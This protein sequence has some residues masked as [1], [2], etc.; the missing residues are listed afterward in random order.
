MISSP[1]YPRPALFRQR[2]TGAIRISGS[3]HLTWL[4]GVVT[5][6]VTAAE[7]GAFWG[8]LLDRMGKIHY[9]V[10]GILEPSSI[11]VFDVSQGTNAL[12]KY[13]DSVLI[14]EDVTL[15]QLNHVD[16]WTVH[17][18]SE[19]AELKTVAGVSGGRLAWADHDD[20]VFA[21][22]VT[23]QGDWLKSA[24]ARGL[25]QASDEQW[26]LLRVQ[27]TLPRFGVDYTEA[28]TPHHAGLFGRA[29]ATNK[30]CYVGQEVVC[31]VEMRGRVARSIVRATL[32]SLDGVEASAVVR[33]KRTGE[34]VGEI[35]SV[36]P[37]M[38]AGP[39]YALA[40]VKVAAIEQHAEIVVGNAS[41]WL[42]D[43]HAAFSDVFSGQATV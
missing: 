11:L 7:R 16:L 31:K 37:A 12:L 6:D 26:E 22:P 1:S 9:E 8:L 13:L 18:F 30:G 14:M 20:W 27:S 28:D 32:D 3:E 29:V 34:V 2:T 15:E 43:P 5:A 4:Q 36:A 10:I 24:E 35:T 21:V 41:G 42:G 39:A 19:A 25:H 23:A 33:E 40:R 17:G 38:D